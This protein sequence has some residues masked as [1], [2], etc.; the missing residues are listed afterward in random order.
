MFEYLLFLYVAEDGPYS[1]T[2]YRSD[3]PV[4]TGHY[5]EWA[6]CP[7]CVENDGGM[8]LLVTGVE[9]HTKRTILFCEYADSFGDDYL[10]AALIEL[11]VTVENAKE[12]PEC[13]RKMRD[14]KYQ[15]RDKIYMDAIR[16]LTDIGVEFDTFP[17]RPP[18]LR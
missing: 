16:A 18:D 5:I 2:D 3:T 17:R 7:E 15:A 9:H 8:R 6:W 10:V 13:V 14:K 4:E 12:K 1:G 11:G